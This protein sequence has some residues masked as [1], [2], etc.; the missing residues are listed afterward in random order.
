MLWKYESSQ[1]KRI[2]LGTLQLLR[3]QGGVY[4]SSSC[5]APFL[6][7]DCSPAL[8]VTTPRTTKATQDAFKAKSSLPMGLGW[9][10]PYIDRC[11]T[12]NGE[13]V[14]TSQ[15]KPNRNGSLIRYVCAVVSGTHGIDVAQRVV[16]GEEIRREVQGSVGENRCVCREMGAVQ[17][18][19]H[20]DQRYVLVLPTRTT[21]SA[22]AQGEG[23]NTCERPHTMKRCGGPVELLTSQD[24]TWGRNA[25]RAPRSRRPSEARSS[26]ASKKTPCCT[27]PRTTHSGT[28]V[29][30]KRWTFMLSFF[31]PYTR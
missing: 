27:A 19:G 7:T 25:E 18:V 29:Q 30:K 26:C 2:H 31:C 14:K 22:H 1:I 16:A 11:C 4:I 5:S 13:I 20:V 3:G 24:G 12:T 6:N 9:H 28:H 10:V 8:L 15:D 21:H 17:D 23:L